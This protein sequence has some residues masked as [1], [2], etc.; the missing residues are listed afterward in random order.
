MTETRVE[1]F[2]LEPTDRARLGLRRFTFGVYHSGEEGYPAPDETPDHVA[3][4]A[5]ALRGEDQYQEGHSTTTAWVAEST[6]RYSEKGD[7]PRVLAA[8]PV[9]EFA[10]D[11]R[12]PTTCQHC[13][14]PMP[15]GAISQVHQDQIWRRVDTGAE[16]TLRDAPAGAMWFAE[17]MS[18]H[19][20]PD[21]R[22]LVVRLPNGMDWLVDS[23]ASNCTKPDDTE[24]R[25]W[26]RHGEPP[27]VTIDKNGNTCDAGAGS[28]GAGSGENYY[29]GFLVDGA[30]VS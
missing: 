19:L 20:G 8:I 28:I 11:P 25:C 14:E 23:R 2:L 27:N 1:C 22:C 4:P 15:S 6:V 17:W 7:R 30:L 10:D 18:F 3:C 26:V 13:D 29:H 21:G 16:C 5:F 9:E 12:W 24:H